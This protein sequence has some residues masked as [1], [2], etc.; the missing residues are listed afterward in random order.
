MTRDG[1]R[2]ADSRQIGAGV[3][4]IVEMAGDKAEPSFRK[5][6]IRGRR[7]GHTMRRLQF[8]GDRYY[9]E[10]KDQPV[11]DRVYNLVSA[12]PGISKRALRD[13]IGG[14][15]DA[16]DQA[17]NDLLRDALI[18]GS[19]SGFL[20]AMS[21][22]HPKSLGANAG[23]TPATPRATL[24][25][26]TA[27]SGPSGHAENRPGHGRATP[28]ATGGT[29]SRNSMRANDGHAVATPSGHAQ[30]RGGIPP[31]MG[32]TPPRAA[33]RRADAGPPGLQANV[34]IFGDDGHPVDA[35]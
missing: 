31:L 27:I 2:Y 30:T 26:A 35:P 12:E 4:V 22:G 32:H 1:T 34:P 7:V 29:K 18:T 25:D 16:V 14:R 28:R 24:D 23:H 6:Q 10:A 3:D 8:A 17:I 20:P 9:L 19:G 33:L 11:I 5:L 21:A 13:R 15:K